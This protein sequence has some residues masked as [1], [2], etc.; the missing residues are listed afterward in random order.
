MR[1]LVFQDSELQVK[2]LPKPIPLEDEALIRILKAGICNTDMGLLKGY[3]GFKGIP[4]H[5]FVGEVI[6]SPDRN[7]IGKRVVG[8]INLSCGKCELCK[9][10]NTNHCSSRRT[11][12]IYKKD[13]AFAEYL[14][15]PLRNIHSLPS[16]ISNTEAVFVEPLAAALEIFEQIE[17]QRTDS[18]LILGDGKLGL[19][20]A[21]VMKQ[22]AEKVLCK[23][24]YQRKLEL[25][26]DRGIKTLLKGQD[27]DD[28]FDIVVE[29]TG[30]EEGLIEGL[31]RVKPCGRII[32]KSTYQGRPCLDVTKVVV[33]EIQMIG[34]R[35]GPFG[36]A[37]E[38]LA[39]KQVEVK[40][41]VDADF[42]L[43]KA[44]EAFEL[45]KKP[46]TMKVLI[47]P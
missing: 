15:L 34:S 14:T 32:L 10:G 13:G 9:R 2:D 25:L 23:G 29:A 43:E 42:H 46:G 7:W 24:K 31:S 41:M 33:D 21:Q 27:I 16:H 18:V 6:K 47:T 11:V 38:A 20:V 28:I 35:C 17:I 39:Q 26:Q 3:L 36:K 4:G 22:K 5:E 45:A 8:E 37:I 12:G 40:K 44:G 1:A 30:N 19:L